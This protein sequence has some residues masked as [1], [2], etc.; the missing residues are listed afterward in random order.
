MEGRYEIHCGDGAAGLMGF[1][2]VDFVWADVPFGQHVDDGNDAETTRDNTFDFEPMTPELMENLALAIGSRC[3]RWAAI[4][5]SEEETHLWRAA[6]ETHGMNYIR[7]GQWVK[8]NPKPQVSGDRPAQ[9]CEP[10][11]LF[12][13]R[14][15]EMR[16]NGGGKP[17]VWYAPVVRGE[18][19]LHPTHTPPQLLKQLV[20]DFTDVDELV[21]DPTA[22]SFEMGVVSVGLGRRFAGWELQ[23]SYCDLAHERIKMPLLDGRPL[24]AALFTPSASSRAANARA[25]LDRDLLRLVNAADPTSGIAKADLQGILGTT[26]AELS[27]SLSRLRKKSLIRRE[28]KTNNSRYFRAGSHAQVASVPTGDPQ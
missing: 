18:A 16:W 15:G 26:P 9:G 14:V 12:H 24:Q 11:L 19:K 23:K 7:T 20:E 8:L 27:R 28:G 17:A 13:S 1:G 25:G 4:K 21:A 5:T 2:E 22:G 10:L 6:M 3:R